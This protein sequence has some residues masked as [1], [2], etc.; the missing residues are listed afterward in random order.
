[1]CILV[2]VAVIRMSIHIL[3]QN[4]WNC[5]HTLHVGMRNRHVKRMVCGYNGSLKLEKYIYLCHLLDWHSYNFPFL[6]PINNY[7]RTLILDLWF[8]LFT[9]EQSLSFLA[10]SVPSNDLCEQNFNKFV[11]NCI[12]SFLFSFSF[13]FFYFVNIYIISF[14]CFI[15]LFL[16]PEGFCISF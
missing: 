13:L 12:F 4:P 7:I 10:F 9:S 5:S 15:I 16:I 2:V 8:K 14:F 11:C 3:H 6:F 1:V